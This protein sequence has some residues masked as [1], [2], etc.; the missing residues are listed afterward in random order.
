MIGKRP[1]TMQRPRDSASKPISLYSLLLVV[2]S[3]DRDVYVH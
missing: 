2:Y 1:S 3:P